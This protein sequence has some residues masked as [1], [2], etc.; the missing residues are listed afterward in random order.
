MLSSFPVAGLCGRC[1]ILAL[2]AASRQ[3]AD[4]GRLTVDP[5]GLAGLAEDL[6]GD[7]VL[8]SPP[9]VVVATQ[10]GEDPV[11]GADPGG[12]AGDAPVQAR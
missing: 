4:R 11:Q 3:A 7:L 8:A 12:V 10:P 2:C 6:P 5:G 1:Q 9:H